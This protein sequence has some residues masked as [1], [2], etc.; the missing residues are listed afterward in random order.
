MSLET[1][2]YYLWEDDKRNGCVNPSDKYYYLL[3]LK[4][5]TFLKSYPLYRDVTSNSF[6][7]CNICLQN[8][9]K[10]ECSRCKQQICH[11]CLFNLQSKYCQY[12][13]TS[14]LLK[15]EK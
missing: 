7:M 5:Q 8:K 3:A 9:S 15:I 10:I 12:C 14:S 4:I 13:R 2:A 6:E 11:I 1:R